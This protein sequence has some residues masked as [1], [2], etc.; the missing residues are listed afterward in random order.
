MFTDSP[1]TPTRVECIIDLLRAHSRREWNRA[2]LIG[3]L[4]PKG[5]PNLTP[6]STQAAESLKACAELELIVETGGKIE[7]TD[8]DRKRSTR[9][10]VL[11]A[12]DRRLLTAIDTEP[13][14]APF[15]SYLLGLGKR[16]T[17]KRHPQEWANAFAHDAPGSQ[18]ERNP[19]NGTKYTGFMRWYGY[20][21]HGWF[22]PEEQFQANPY[23]RLLRQLPTIF[24]E[25]QQLDGEE[26]MQRLAVGCPELDGGHLYCRVW[27]AYDRQNRVCSL[28]MSHALVDLH[29]DNHIRL[30]CPIDSR[31]WSI[32][33]A[34][35]PNDG[36]TLRSGR[37]DHIEWIG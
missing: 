27:P 5:L 20:S 37:I 13:Y 8:Y 31:G 11:D 4:Q 29:L 22:D 26:F 21:G 2:E 24:G 16:A 34:Q 14:Y 10:I 9:E 3:V 36:K 30:H 19:F 28:G 23:E 35:P 6:N 7:L 15:Y 25:D 18:G 33:A 17:A 32:E 1:A 12:I